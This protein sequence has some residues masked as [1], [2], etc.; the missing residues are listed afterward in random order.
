MH[1]LDHIWTFVTNLINVYIPSNILQI[2][3]NAVV[4]AQAFISSLVSRVSMFTFTFRMHWQFR[5]YPLPF[6]PHH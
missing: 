2:L 5:A 4:H 3:M 1:F 6:T